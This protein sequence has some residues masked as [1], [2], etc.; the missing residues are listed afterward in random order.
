MRKQPKEPLF[1]F[2]IDNNNNLDWSNSE[3]TLDQSDD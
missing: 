3:F 1:E 2:N